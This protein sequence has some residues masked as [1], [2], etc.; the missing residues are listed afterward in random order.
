MEHGSQ[1]FYGLM[2]EMRL[3]RR[4]LTQVRGVRWM[5][6]ESDGSNCE[7][8]WEMRLWRRALTQVRWVTG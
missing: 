2:E 3:W 5:G 7:W 4:A 8:M 6:D 1:D